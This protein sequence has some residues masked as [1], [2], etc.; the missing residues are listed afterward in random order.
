[1]PKDNGGKLVERDEN[2]RVMAG[3]VLNPN[4]RPK[5]ALNF[6]TKWKIFIE[7]VA[8]ETGKTPE[9]IDEQLY[10]VAYNAATDGDY[11]FYR[12]IQDRVF[13]KAAQPIVGKD[14]ENIM[15]DLNVDI[16]QKADKYAPKLRASDILG[17]GKGLEPDSE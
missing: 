15:V 5:G 6:A 12:D 11:N 10:R 2:G 7:K 1:M 13:G 16:K 17:V 8:E 3:S 4:G 9:Q 14:G